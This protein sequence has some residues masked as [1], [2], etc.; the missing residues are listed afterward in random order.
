M[1]VLNGVYRRLSDGLMLS[2]AFQSRTTRAEIYSSFH[3]ILLPG[4][5]VGTAPPRGFRL[6]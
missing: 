3:R 6:L 1:T 4:T 5:A 2:R